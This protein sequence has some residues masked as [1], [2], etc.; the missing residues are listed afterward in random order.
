AGKF[1]MMPAQDATPLSLILT[2]LVTNCVEHGFEDR[3]QGH[4][5]ISALRASNDLHIIIEDDGIGIDSEADADT[6]SAKSS[7]S[8]LG[9]QIVNTFVQND[10]NGSIHWAPGENGGTR[11]ELTM[12]LRAA[13]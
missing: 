11:I 10:F 4:I 8:G 1:G 13:E 12:T 9:T 5:Q 6:M 3:K 2:E 7:G